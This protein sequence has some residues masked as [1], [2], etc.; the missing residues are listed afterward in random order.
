M[1]F[2]LV[3]L[4]ATAISL[5]GLGVGVVYGL[6]GTIIPWRA[7]LLVAMVST[8]TVAVAFFF[9]SS[10]HWLFSPRIAV[11]VGRIILVIVGMWLFFQ[12]WLAGARGRANNADPNGENLQLATLPLK[13][14]GIVI[15][16]MRHPASADLDHSGT[17]SSVEALLLGL[18]LA[19]DAF[20]AGAGAGAVRN[21]PYYTPLLVGLGKFLFLSAGLSFGRVWAK[22]FFLPW[23]NYLPGLLLILL[24]M[25]GF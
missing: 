14:L 23:I 19:T 7:R 3:L 13:S 10:L 8:I 16:I 6:K 22:N 11:I 18:A 25:I 21:W 9:G 24:A 5:D 1:N 20:G 15:L 17:I 4:L 2:L 12:G